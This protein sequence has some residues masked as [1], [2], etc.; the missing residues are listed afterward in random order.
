M[1]CFSL[2]FYNTF[3]YTAETDVIYFALN[4][5]KQLDIPVSK[6]Y[7]FVSGDIESEES[8]FYQQIKHYLPTASLVNPITEFNY[9]FKEAPH[10]LYHLLNLHKCE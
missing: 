9:A 10:L 2:L 8:E 7:V 1:H 3:P 5:L 4:V 6:C